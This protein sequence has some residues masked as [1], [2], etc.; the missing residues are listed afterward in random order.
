MGISSHQG[1]V[2]VFTRRPVT[3]FWSLPWYDWLFKAYQDSLMFSH[4]MTQPRSKDAVCTSSTME[5]QCQ[6]ER[7]SVTSWMNEHVHEYMQ[8]WELDL[9]S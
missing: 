4:E 9:D 1:A 5:L 7:K 8:A 3:G 6:A 2:D